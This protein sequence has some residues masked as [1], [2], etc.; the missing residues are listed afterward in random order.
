[1][2]AVS[3][4]GADARVLVAPA[5]P[6]QSS[7][8]LASPLRLQGPDDPAVD[9]DIQRLKSMAGTPMRNLGPRSPNGSSSQTAEPASASRA[10]WL[11]GLIYLQGAGVTRDPNQAQLWFERAHA[12]G[13][14]WSSAGLAWC[15]IEGCGGSPDPAAA[16]RWIAQLRNVDLPRAQYLEWVVQSRMSPLQIATPRLGQIDSGPA[17][18]ARELLIRAAQGG[19]MHARIELGLE[20]VA[21]SRL[22]EALEYF[23][24]AAPKSAAASANMAIISDRIKNRLQVRPTSMSAA[25]LLASAQ[26]FHRG[27]GRPANYA[28]AIR[29]YRLAEV[30]GSVEARRML[31]LI[32]SRTTFE[33]DLD[34]AWMQQLGNLD[35]S[36]DAPGLVP[37][38]G[39]RQLQ[40]EP[41][42]L[43][44]LLP[45]VWRK[46]TH[47]VSR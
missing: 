47:R 23:K 7:P 3:L 41:S 11:L 31:A 16:R 29:L 1:M 4:S 45:E 2:L 42:P 24:A 33:G 38:T 18:P 46:R 15:Q 44:D 14:P 25:D 5:Q 27:E 39:T 13:D 9:R 20:S 36:K 10:A 17:L 6:I 32:F 22:P 26:Q 35:L 30:K 21:A 37:V 12:L 8:L 43:F 40:R 19:D 34:V 28:E